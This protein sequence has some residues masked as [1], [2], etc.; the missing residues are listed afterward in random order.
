MP[1]PHRPPRILPSS[2]E[3]GLFALLAPL[4]A[5]AIACGGGGE[6]AGSGGGADGGAPSGKKRLL[7]Y[8]TGI[9]PVN[10]AAWA[11][12]ERI[13]EAA[14]PDI[15]VDVKAF[16]DDDYSQGGKLIAAL[17]SRT[18][19]DIYFEW[20]WAAVTRDAKNGNALD[21]TD[22]IDADL[23]AALD[24]KTFAGTD[25]EGRTYMIPGA[26]DVA[27]LI[28]YRK[29]TLAEHGIEPPKTWEE[30]VAAC[31]KL[32][33]AG[34]VPIHQ[35]NLAAW[36]AGNWAAELSAVYLGL[37]RYRQAGE[38]PPRVLLTDDGF[39]QALERLK[40]LRDAGAFNPDIDTLNDNEGIAGFA[41][42]SGAFIFA[43]AWVLDSLTEAG[44]DDFGVIQRPALPGA[45]EGPRY[46]LAN[47]TG[48]MV[49]SKCPIPDLAVELIR[50]YN[51]YEAQIPRVKGGLN[52][53]NIKAQSEAQSALRAE[54]LGILDASEAWVAAPDISWERYTAERFYAAVKEVVNGSKEPREALE[55]AAADV[56][57]KLR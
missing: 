25:H 15:D 36:P 1:T 34:V 33:T 32:K 11:E 19:P 21:L 13:F 14:H 28:F 56:A 8:D 24:P 23:R 47:A 52:S 38:N 17:R 27:N 26:F 3:R 2:L 31:A 18:P 10:R 57:A 6:E 53:C 48:Y 51:S 46:L 5:L 40:E 22:R 49:N 29:A 7:V 45:P 54:V 30:F 44:I 55:A 9:E 42:G 50:N 16:K 37:D 39:V 43:G 35:G 41:S 12:A 4:V 20:T